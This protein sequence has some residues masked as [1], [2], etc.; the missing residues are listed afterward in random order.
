[1]NSSFRKGR[2]LQDFPKKAL[3]SEFIYIRMA[4]M[5]MK[6]PV[7]DRDWMKERAEKC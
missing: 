3:T 7:N 4:E 1:M 6:N 5:K 2:V